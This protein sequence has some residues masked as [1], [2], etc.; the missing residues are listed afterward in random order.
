MELSAKAFPVGVPVR[1]AGQLAVLGPLRARINSE[2]M[3]TNEVPVIELQT[4]GSVDHRAWDAGIDGPGVRVRVDAETHL[5]DL[6][7]VERRIALKQRDGR[8]P[9]VVLLLADTR[10]HQLVLESAGGALRTR[11]PV[12]QRAALRALR[13]GRSPGG[14]ALIR[15]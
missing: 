11:F 2:L 6:Q 15:L 13:N 14:N 5:G 12:S 9:C 10:H 8:E 7:A 3:W 4:A 1:D